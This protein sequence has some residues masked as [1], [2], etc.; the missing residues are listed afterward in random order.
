MKNRFLYGTILMI[1]GLLSMHI[2]AALATATTYVD[3]ANV[4]GRL[5]KN[6]SFNISVYDINAT[7]GEDLFAWELKINW[8]D[9]KFNFVSAVEGPFLKQGG[10]TFFASPKATKAGGNETLTLASSLVGAVPGVTGSGVLATVT[11]YYNT[12]TTGNF[13]DLFGVKLRRSDLN[14]IPTIVVL[15]GQFVVPRDWDI[16]PDFGSVDIYDLV[17][18]G[19]NFGKT[20]TPGFIDADVDNDGNVDIDDLIL[21]AQNYGTYSL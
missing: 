15:D 14:P 2:A 18:V 3:P 16:N 7:R 4:P 5:G 20:G 1:I 11:V 9:S 21:V 13:I 17:D 6:A 12:T 10:D 19:I 8:T